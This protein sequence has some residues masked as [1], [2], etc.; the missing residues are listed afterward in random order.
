MT[1]VQTLPNVDILQNSN[2]HVSVVHDTTVTCLG[3]LVVLDILC[4]LM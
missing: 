3:T 1:R 4:M 2:G